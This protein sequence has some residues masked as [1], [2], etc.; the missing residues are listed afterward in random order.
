MSWSGPERGEDLLALGVGQLV[1]RQLVVVA[2]EA[3]TGASSGVAGRAA[4][5]SP[6]AAR[7]AARQREVQRLV[8]DEVE[9]HVQLVAVLVAEELAHAPAAAG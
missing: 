2:H 5:P 9:H 8:A 6:A 4:A 7:I 1:E 3:P